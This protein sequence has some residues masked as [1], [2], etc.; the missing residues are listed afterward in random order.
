MI[1]MLVCFAS[2]QWFGLLWNGGLLWRGI[3]RW[4]AF[5][6][7][8]A[9][10]ANVKAQRHRSL[11]IINFFLEIL[12]P[13]GPSS[14]S[15]ITRVNIAGAM[16]EDMAATEPVTPRIHQANAILPAASP[17]TEMTCPVRNS[18]KFFP[19]FITKPLFL[20]I[21]R[22][23]TSYR[24]AG[25]NFTRLAAAHPLQNLFHL[26]AACFFVH[27]VSSFK[28]ALALTA[29]YAYTPYRAIFMPMLGGWVF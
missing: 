1:G 2:E 12:S 5:D 27:F 19:S 22:I 28:F 9:T 3:R 16:T 18:Q 11:I 8:S 10:S 20:K 7:I 21:S 26:L 25:Y 24:N 4:K 17:M 23:P 13:I 29:D 14:G 15:S 6:I